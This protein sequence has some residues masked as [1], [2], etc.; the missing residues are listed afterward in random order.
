MAPPG[1]AQ[2]PVNAIA[3][4]ESA[5]A[6]VG[7]PNPPRPRRRYGAG[8]P[9]PDPAGSS[10]PAAGSGAVDLAG[11]VAGTGQRVAASF[12]ERLHAVA[13]A[14]QIVLLPYGD[15]D[16]V[17]LVR[18]GMATDVAT[19][20]RAW[21]G[22]GP[23][24]VGRPG[25]GDLRARRPPTAY[26]IDGAA[27]GADPGH[28]GRRRRP[29]PVCCPGVGGRA[30]PTPT[31]GPP[32]C[33]VIETDGAGPALPSVVAQT[34]VLGGLD[35]L[36]DDS[37]QTG[38]A[39]KVNSLT[40]LLAQQRA[41]GTT[42]P[43]VFAPT[44]R[45]SP[46]SAALTGLVQLLGELGRNGVISGESLAAL[47]AA[48]VRSGTTDYPVTARRPGALG[49]VP[50]AD[51]DGPDRGRRP[52]QRAHFGEPA[53][54]PGDAARPTG[55]RAGCG[56]VDRVPD[57]PRRGRGQPGHRRIHACR[58]SVSGV[59]IAAS[60]GNSYTLASSTSPLVLTVQNNLPYDV[61]VTVQITGGEMVGLTVNDQPVQIVPAGRSQQVKIPTEVTRSGQFQV[62]ATLI[63]PDGAAWGSPGATVGPVHRLRRPHRH[64][65][66]GGRRGAGP[67]GCAADPCS[68]CGGGAPGS[69]PRALPTGTDSAA[70]P[71]E[72]QPTRRTPRRPTRRPHGRPIGPCRDDTA[73][74]PRP[75]KRET[76]GIPSVTTHEAS[77][78][79]VRASP[80]TGPTANP[81]ATRQRS[82]QRPATTSPG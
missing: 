3:E 82:R 27:D 51:R 38:W 70:R 78:E 29:E 31:A 6:T 44:R 25:F 37:Q 35:K 5:T 60:S 79:D 74:R 16:V 11:T 23:A 15:P 56:R 33:A 42:S 73:S 69:P 50:A 10:D 48:A 47:S 7:A 24:G 59:Q 58:P 68:V 22:G 45:W 62:T 30:R 26:P 21:T 14:H 75:S 49:G 17:A 61:P 66:R 32:A 80:A 1:A 19:A 67:H 72:D 63:G 64:P 77:G 4:A 12:L 53:V 55:H 20:Q 28:P 13:A 18:A 8:R 71:A 36:I 43:A 46:D 81:T 52:A 39:T 57:G 40:A 9:G 65:D 34:D 2:P 41:D 54:R 76:A